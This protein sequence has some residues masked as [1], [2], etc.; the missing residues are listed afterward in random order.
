MYNYGNK[1]FLF[2]LKKHPQYKRALGGQYVH[3]IMGYVIFNP[4]IRIIIKYIN[5]LID[6]YWLKRYM[7]IDSVIRGARK[8]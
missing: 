6:N 2:L 3:S 7:V 8:T 4:L 5:K 1:N